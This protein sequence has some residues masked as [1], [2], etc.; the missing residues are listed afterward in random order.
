MGHNASYLYYY[1]RARVIGALRALESC[2]A[3]RNGGYDERARPFTFALGSEA[4]TVTASGVTLTHPAPAPDGET[5]PTRVRTK[6]EQRVDLGCPAEVDWTSAYFVVPIPLPP[7]TPH[8]WEDGWDE[9]PQKRQPPSRKDVIAPDVYVTMQGDYGCLC[10]YSRA[11]AYDRYFIG[12]P[13]VRRMGLDF[14][15]ATGAVLILED[16]E[17]DE[18]CRLTE[19]AADAT[20]WQPVRDGPLSNTLAAWGVAPRAG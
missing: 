1:P 5:R 3:N 20:G 4:T 16:R 12:S 9:G 13:V 19:Q 18:V 10:L 7:G 15:T 11:R 2:N 6:C 17:I 8:P 14:G